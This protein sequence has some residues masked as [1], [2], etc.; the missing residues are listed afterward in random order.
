MHLPVCA[1][2]A[3]K[4]RPRSVQL[5]S[6][7]E[8]NREMNTCKKIGALGSGFCPWHANQ[9]VTAPRAEVVVEISMESAWGSVRCVTGAVTLNSEEISQQMTTGCVSR[10]LI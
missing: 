5:L 10:I 4:D 7:A 6:G 2:Q 3:M 8:L 9:A 1:S